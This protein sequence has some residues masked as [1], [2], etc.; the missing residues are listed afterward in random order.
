MD[1]K[2]SKLADIINQK[3]PVEILDAVKK[4]FNYYYKIE[5]FIEV[6]KC[7]E[8][9]KLLF[10]GHFPGYKACN[11]GYHNLFHTL[12]TFLAA[13]RLIDGYN[14]SIIVLPIRI[15]KNLLIAALFHDVGYIQENIDD[16]GTGA[17][18]TQNHVLRGVT[19]ISKNFNL[20]EINNNDISLI[21]NIIKCTDLKI[22]IGD[23]SFDSED[24]REAGLI[25]ATADILGQMADREYLEKL[26]FLYHEFKEAGIPGYNTEFDIMKNTLVFYKEILIRLNKIYD[27]KYKYVEHHFNKRY[28]IN[29][30]LYMNAI[31]NNI[32]YIKKII[33]ENENNFRSKL[34]RGSFL[35]KEKVLNF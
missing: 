17:K 16:D 9:I 12:D 1:D 19:F 2:K 29:E 8:K 21:S 14:I 23:I 3:N 24:E 26:L 20:F 5:E 30:N 27:A 28:Q 15:V 7:F 6:E 25:L 4:I 22:I 34:R 35:E 18:Y 32:D 10:D 11:T 13:A 33:K 31:N